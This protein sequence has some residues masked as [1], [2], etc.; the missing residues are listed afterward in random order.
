MPPPIERLSS[1]TSIA[2]R[3][4][5]ERREQP[6]P[7]RRRESIESAGCLI[8]WLA[9]RHVRKGLNTP[10]RHAMANESWSHGE[11]GGSR[12]AR[13]VVPIFPGGRYPGWGTTTFPSLS[14]PGNLPHMTTGVG[15][16]GVLGHED[17][18]WQLGVNFLLTRH[19]AY[20][21]LR[22]IVAPAEMVTLSCYWG[23]KDIRH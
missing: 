22:G 14:S 8:C 1:C 4:G 16:R 3:G 12:L 20:N 2:P 6:G 19:V 5:D 9:G 17:V 18:P 15:E 23:Q 11:S 21:N 13:E 10:M 7:R